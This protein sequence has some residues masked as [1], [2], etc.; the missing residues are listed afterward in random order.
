MQ[1]EKFAPGIDWR[2]I[3]TPVVDQGNYGDCQSWASKEA[4][5][6]AFK[7]D[8]KLSDFSVCYLYYWYQKLAGTSGTYSGGFP[9]QLAQIL[10]ANGCAN[11]T[12]WPFD[13]T[14]YGEVP[15]DAVQAD[16]KTLVPAGTVLTTGL[17]VNLAAIKR[18]LNQGA[19]VILVIN[20]TEAFHGV[21]GPLE[22]HAWDLNSNYMG[23]HVMCAHG[24]TESGRL[25][26]KQTWG[27]W[28]GDKGYVG[29]PFEYL[30]KMLVSAMGFSKLPV[31]L[32]ADPAYVPYGIPTFNSG[33]QILELPQVAWIENPFAGAKFFKNVRIKIVSS[34]GDATPN[35]PKFNSAFGTN[36]IIRTNMAGLSEVGFPQL[37]FDGVLY[38]NVHV[39]NP[40]LD[41]ISA[42]PE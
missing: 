20:D 30:P 27:D 6:L 26:A 32:H 35:S 11:S 36:Y 8:G 34:A 13:T 33:T 4:L 10:N 23:Q 25:I 7:R 28:W 5:D 14:H 24:Y 39:T 37:I 19:P 42:E 9:D 29:I 2:P 38:Y 41:L 21:T 12:E 18:S 1:I 3:G 16:A 15:P 31:A 22:T 17:G 40:N